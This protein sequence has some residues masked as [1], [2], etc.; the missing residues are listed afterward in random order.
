M[1]Y[2]TRI[3]AKGQIVIPKELRERYGYKKGVELLVVSLDEN[4]LLLERVPKLSEMFGILGDAIA[5]KVLLKHREE[6]LSAEEERKAELK[7]S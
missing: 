1:S 3:S 6:E 7:R 5:S 4:R 2:R